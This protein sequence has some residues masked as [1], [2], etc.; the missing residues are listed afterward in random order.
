MSWTSFNTDIMC[1]E[2]QYTTIQNR[3]DAD[4][5]I[6]KSWPR[7]DCKARR[8][9]GTVFFPSSSSANIKVASIQPRPT[10]R[11]NPQSYCTVWAIA[12]NWRCGILASIRCVSAVFV[13]PTG[14]GVLRVSSATLAVPSL[15][16][17]H[18]LRRY[19]K[20]NNTQYRY[21]WRWAWNR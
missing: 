1:S 18:F 20:K 15:G 3:A 16:F 8:N 6:F 19:L 2:M 4:R 21:Y 17:A 9:L 7:S 5:S 13:L 14:N 11:R 12:L 10:K